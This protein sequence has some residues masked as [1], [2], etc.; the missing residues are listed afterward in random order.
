MVTRL[1]A[2]CG[3]NHG[4]F[5]G[6]QKYF[7]FLGKHQGQLW[8]SAQPCIQQEPRAVSPEIIVYGHEVD[9]SPPLLVWL[10]MGGALLH[11][12]VCLNG[13]HRDNFTFSFLLLLLNVDV[14]HCVWTLI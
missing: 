11:S 12:L 1:Q 5:S 9:L 6:R 3:E 7:S 4:S 13:M 10:K 14:L 2:G 8:G